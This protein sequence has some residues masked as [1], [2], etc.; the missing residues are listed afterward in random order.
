MNIV[1]S[2]SDYFLKP[3]ITSI[4]SLVNHN[5]VTNIIIL[6][7]DL[8]Y[9]SIELI[10][11]IVKK[12]NIIFLKCDDIIRDKLS[13]LKLKKVRGNWNTYLRVFIPSLF[14]EFDRILYID[15]DTL[16]NGDILNFYNL[17]FDDNYFAASI[18]YAAKSKYSNIE[19]KEILD[20]GE[21]YN[22]GI[23]LLNN[24]K[25]V[26]INFTEQIL[27]FLEK[28]K[29]KFRVADQSIINY[30]YNNKFKT[31]DIGYN[32]YSSLHYSNSIASNLVLGV[33]F[34]NYHK[35]KDKIKIIH[36]IG[37]WF[38]RPWFKTHYSIFSKTYLNVFSS[39]GFTKD[40]LL[41]TPKYSKHYFYDYAMLFLRKGGFLTIEFYFR[42]LVMQKLKAIIKIER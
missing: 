2:T 26:E 11:R 17:N 24:S 10:K 27:A 21:Y 36:F 13:H 16:I 38:E 7:S 22:C 5:E 12:C 20:K 1:Y 6:H 32:F 19:S 3:T 31:V 30:L 42:Y 37:H 34:T 14:P 4:V 33:D 23:L 18:D 40:D 39:C 41:E 29:L 15:S 9:D 8:S 28:T 25:L 35:N